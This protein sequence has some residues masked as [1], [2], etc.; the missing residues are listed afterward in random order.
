MHKIDQKKPNSTSKYIGV[1]FD[2][3]MH[4]WTSS[5]THD[6]KTLHL[7]SFENEIEAA[8]VYDVYAIYSYKKE[9]PKTNNLLTKEEIKDIRCNGIPE[10]YQKKE[11]IRDL[12]KY[13]CNANNNTYRF[14]ITRDSKTYSKTVKTLEEAILLKTEF[15]EKIE[16]SKGLNKYSKE[17]TRNINGLAIIYMFSGLEC[18]VNEDHWY[19]LNQYK[20]N[21]C[22]NEN[23]EIY[24]YPF[25]Y[26]NG[27]SVKLHRYIY[28]KYIGPIPSNMTV[29]HVKSKNILDVRLKNLRLADRSLQNH[30]KDMSQN[31]IDEYKGICF[32]S[33][34]YTVIINECYY[35]T[36]K[37]AEEAAKKANEIYIKIYGNQA[38]LNVIDDSKKTTKYNRI[39]IENI[40]KEYIRNLTKVCDVKSVVIIKGLN[41][42]AGG[43]IKLA[44]I[45]LK[46][47]D[48]Y[49]QIIIDTL[50]P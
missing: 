32:N 26:V 50:Y 15:L 24:G 40:T 13:I 34:G 27:K 11:K 3:G 36:Y 21:Y 25:G 39:P 1:S 47:I 20:W 35:G 4:K 8:K 37:V 18:I 12:P 30:N 10:K 48:E 44:D 22:K 14:R 49:K 29:D 6:H 45:K 7:G 2:K 33:S 5:I 42:N 28:E 16:E 38:T 9:S 19:D 41:N 46:T 31:R 43:E 23:D 17:I